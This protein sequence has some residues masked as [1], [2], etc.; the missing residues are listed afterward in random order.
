MKP[1][2][3]LHYMDQDR[4]KV[5]YTLQELAIG[6]GHNPA[7]IAKILNSSPDFVRSAR[8]S[9]AGDQ[10]FASKHDFRQHTS[11]ADKIIGAFKNRID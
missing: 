9:D 6:T 1:E 10:V 8:P 7:D 4:D 3:L 5:W 11:I 2:K